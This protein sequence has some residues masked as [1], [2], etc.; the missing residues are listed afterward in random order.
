MKN[1][2]IAEVLTFLLNGQQWGAFT[3]DASNE[4]EFNDA[5]TWTGTGEKPTWLQVSNATIPIPTPL[6]PAEK[7]FNATGLTVTDLKALGL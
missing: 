7:L 3:G 5:F 4:Q 2:E 6:T 1:K